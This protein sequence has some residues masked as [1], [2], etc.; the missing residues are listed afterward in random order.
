ML[1]LLSGTSCSCTRVSL[2]MGVSSTDTPSDDIDTRGSALVPVSAGER[3]AG[4]TEAVEGDVFSA[5]PRVDVGTT[6]ADERLSI[7]L[8]HT[9]NGLTLC[10]L[11]LAAT[12]SARERRQ[13]CSDDV[14]DASVCD[15]PSYIVVI[16]SS[17]PASDSRSPSSSAPSS[18][19]S[20]VPP[21][22]DTCGMPYELAADACDTSDA[23][24]PAVGAGRK[25]TAE[26]ALNSVCDGDG[27]VRPPSSMSEM[28]GAPPPDFGVRTTPRDKNATSNSPSSPSTASAASAAA[29]DAPV[30]GVRPV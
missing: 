14:T 27:G 4:P 16:D 18:S 29:G 1:V 21:S 13:F 22:T 2:L 6:V 7:E 9:W 8:V 17:L 5:P 3:D 23:R 11:L 30:S 28:R 20:D 10:P 24:L 15:E 12:Y 19:S 26:A 25:S